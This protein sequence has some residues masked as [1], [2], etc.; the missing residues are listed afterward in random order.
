[1]FLVEVL[2]NGRR[3]TVAKRYS[4]F[5]A[6]HKRVRTWGRWGQGVCSQGPSLGTHS[7]DQG[8]HTPRY[9]PDQEELQGARLPP[10]A[11]PQLGAQSA[12]AA[13]AGP[14]ALHPGETRGAGGGTCSS[15]VPTPPRP[16]PR[17]SCATMRSYP[18][19]C[20]TS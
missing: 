6:L 3:H 15:G 19:M 11:C 12:G 4:E 2:C 9:A 10:T 17:A 20:W 13:P 5:Q 18:R 14:G 16:H 1:M 8:T 7:G